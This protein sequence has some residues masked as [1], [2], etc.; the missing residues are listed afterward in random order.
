MKKALILLG[1]NFVAVLFFF[2]VSE[3]VIRAFAPQIT[4]QGT[5][6]NIFVDSLYYASLGLKPLS[7]GKTNGA[8]VRVDQYGFR[9]TSIKIDR[10][11]DSWLFLGDSV[12][13][14]I[15]VEADSTF[16]G[17]VQYRLDS[18][19]VLNPSAIA[20]NIEDYVNLFRYFVL[21]QSYDFKIRRVT[22]FWCLNDV[23]TNIPDVIVPGGKIRYLF[24]DVLTFLQVHSRLYFFT[25]TLLFDRPKSYFLF[26]KAFYD[27][28]S[29]EFLNA[30]NRIVEISNLSRNRKILFDLILLPYEYQLREPNSQNLEPQKLMIE[31]LKP[32]GINVVNPFEELF[33]K[34]KNSKDY[35]LYGDGIHFSKYGHRYVAE[36]VLRKLVMDSKVFVP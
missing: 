4:T 1:Y 34:D 11:K 6:K 27:K 18:I 25:K 30:I 28:E 26:D 22:I 35:F 8:E 17:I 2:L 10:S 13:F 20:Y 5:S 3:L 36:F 33:S 24:S 7:S 31:K 12:T 21:D 29:P 23:S 19:N 14:G 16:A 15:G 32:K 9:E